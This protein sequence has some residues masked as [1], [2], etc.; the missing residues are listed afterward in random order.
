[1]GRLVIAA[2]GAAVGYIVG[3]PAGAQYGW[4]I[5]SVVGAVTAPPNRVRG[6]RI[7][8]LRV[9]GVEYGQ[10]IPFV[11]GT[12]TVPGQIWWASD[13]REIATTTDEGGKGGPSTEVTSYT[14][15]V[16]LLIG[17]SENQ[18]G[19]VVRIWSQGKLVYSASAS[20]SSDTIDAS[21]NTSAWTRMTFYSGESTQLPDPTYEAAVGVGNAPAYRNRST[22][23]I[24]G[25]QLGSSGQIPNLTFEVC[26]TATAGT[27]A[28]TLW[29]TTNGT[30]GPGYA[31]AGTPAFSRA[32]FILPYP[33]WNENY[34]TTEVQ[35]KQFDGVN[36]IQL[37]PYNITGST[38]V[39]C[40]GVTDVSC[41]ALHSPGDA[42]IRLWSGAEGDL[43]TYNFASS[44]LAADRDCFARRASRIFF[45]ASSSS[46]DEKVY[47]FTVGTSDAVATSAALSQ[48]V[49]RIA[50]GD[51]SIFCLANDGSEVYQ[52][53][54]GSMALAATI[55]A[56]AT[57]TAVMC[58]DDGT[59]YLM[60]S[61]ALYRRDGA[62]WTLITSS[63]PAALQAV[64]SQ[65]SP[66]MV[67]GELYAMVPSNTSTPPV[68][69]TA[70]MLQ[71]TIAPQSDAL[72]DVVTDLCERAGLTSAHIDVS[73]IESDAE[74][75]RGFALTQV[76]ATRTAM[77]TLQ[78]AFFFDCVL[79]DKLYFRRRGSGS[80]R[81]ITF[82]ELG[83]VSNGD[84]DSEP[85]KL[86]P[87][88]ELE[89]PSGIAVRYIN[90][91]ADYTTDMQQ[92][93]RLLSAA[94]TTSLIEMPIVLTAEEA[95][96]IA[97]V[98]LLDLQVAT[99][100]S[101][102]LALLNT[103][104]DL[105]PTDVIV[106]ED[107]DESTY[108]FRLVHRMDARGV[109]E[110][111][112][113]LDDASVLEQA[114][115]TSGEY[116]PTVSVSAPASTLLVPMDIPILR[117]ADDDPGY[118]VAAKGVDS[119][120]P[121]ASI[122]SSPDDTTYTQQVSF[123]SASVIGDAITTLGDWTGGNVVDE[124]NTVTVDVG[125]GTLSS[126]SRETLLASTENACL[127]GSE[128]LQFQTATL[129]TDGYYT[130]SG[131]LRGRRG[132]EWAM[133]DHVADETFV[134]LTLTGLRRIPVENSDL[135][136]LRYLKG[137]TT[138]R[139]L[140]TAGAQE[141]TPQAVGLKPFSPVDVRAE[142]DAGTN[143]ITLSW[144]RRT[145]IA[146]RFGGPLGD[147]APLGEATEA[148]SI[149]VYD[150]DTFTTVVRTIDA[151]EQSASYTSAQQVADFGSN[152]ATIYVR[153]YQISAVVGRGYAAEASV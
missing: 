2:A 65:Q 7:E 138:G 10:P 127:I 49:K 85:L 71:Y 109:L 17:L 79:S 114:G 72:A 84:P 9:T 152:Q 58:D 115:V 21:V 113:V 74:M 40:P 83:A 4:A 143:D 25:L 68:T 64:A 36:G 134:L 120:W 11:V 118:Y 108:R 31:R 136:A 73:D 90:A 96:A 55:T 80:I 37:T 29:G 32:P 95:K 47:Q 112:A 5:G 13:R 81:T 101:T 26:R 141:F 97:D 99:L 77:E 142:R 14:Y 122:F 34:L 149:D 116:T 38:P 54:I 12:I 51:G 140:G 35:V 33:A 39:L 3:G 60:A 93:D 52:L 132:T 48:G 94:R 18:L 126:I 105:E 20:A 16:D 100:A 124:T 22:I 43:S 23:F 91:D 146:T 144:T 106:V 102:K 61:A 147:S 66:S 107:E 103:H 145:R 44:T 123:T 62:S 76:G 15:E 86:K 28:R 6:P 150:D 78:S 53:T 92:S 75:V 30:S 89:L 82:E 98:M 67:D 128:V 137:V 133:I 1:M 42:F 111:D 46:S 119:P 139:T 87:G 59:L 69:Y 130:L 8:D 151:T 88:S 41:M 63:L 24:E 50:A 148:Y 104:A 110:F 153:V 56:P 121:G 131:L 57:G 45:G 70:S 135:G 19:G 117:D 129:D 125:S 27:A